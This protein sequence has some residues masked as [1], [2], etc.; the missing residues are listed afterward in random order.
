MKKISLIFI[1]LVLGC[2][3]TGNVKPGSTF[4]LSI[5]LA[6][7]STSFLEEEDRLNTAQDL[8]GLESQVVS[9]RNVIDGALTN[10]GNIKT[11]VSTNQGKFGSKDLLA[12]NDKLDAL[13]TLLNNLKTKAQTVRDQ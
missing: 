5:A 3:V 9:A 10:L 8:R 4:G 6:D 2:A 12:I 11:K 1:L 13:I 7:T